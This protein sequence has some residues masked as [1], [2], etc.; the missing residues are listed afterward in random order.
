MTQH[1]EMLNENKGKPGEDL[2]EVAL[3]RGVP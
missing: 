3:F 2:M 1:N